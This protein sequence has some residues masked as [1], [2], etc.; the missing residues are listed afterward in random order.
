MPHLKILKGRDAGRVIIL[1]EEHL[2]GRD[3]GNDIRVQDETASR[4]H[5]RVQRVDRALVVIDLGSNNG[6]FVNGKKITEHEAMVK[7]RTLIVPSTMCP[8]SIS[9]S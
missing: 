8:S 6:T 1:E 3:A 2:I 4:H 5:A 9:S 7:N